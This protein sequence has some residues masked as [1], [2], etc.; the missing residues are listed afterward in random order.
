MQEV[1]KICSLSSIDLY[2]LAVFPIFGLAP[3]LPGV[4]SL[5]VLA[6]AVAS[7]VLSLVVLIVA[8]APSYL[9]SFVLLAA[10]PVFE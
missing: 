5:V 10:A 7:Q 4:F 8:V 9:S 3:L 2:L 6:V 1:I